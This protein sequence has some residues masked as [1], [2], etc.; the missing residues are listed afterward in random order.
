MARILDPGSWP[1]W[2]P[3]IT[4]ADGPA[5]VQ[6][7]DDVEGRASLLGFEVDG[8]S[9]IVRA[10]SAELEQ[11]VLVGVRM[12]VRYEVQAIP[13]GS[14]VTHRIEAVMPGGLSGRL[15]SLFLRPRLRRVQRQLLENLARPN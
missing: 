8:R 11:D 10:G 3:E 15:V 7:G 9:R 4:V 14:R 13:G 5:R 6:A 2:Q 12:R 1:R